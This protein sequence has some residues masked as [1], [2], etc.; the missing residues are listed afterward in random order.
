MSSSGPIARAPRKI[1]DQRRNND[2]DQHASFSLLDVAR[3]RVP[4]GAV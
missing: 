1:A 4:L 2:D 3:H